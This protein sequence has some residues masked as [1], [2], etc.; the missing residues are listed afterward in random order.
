MSMEQYNSCDVKMLI[1]VAVPV[2][3]VVDYDADKKNLVALVR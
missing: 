1:H 2:T 3:D